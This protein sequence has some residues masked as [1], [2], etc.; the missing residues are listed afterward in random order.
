M[1]KSKKRPIIQS[2]SED[3]DAGSEN[4]LDQVELVNLLVITLLNSHPP[5]LTET[6]KSTNLSK[7]TL[8]PITNHFKAFTN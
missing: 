6:Y 1:S 5:F 7:N 8:G 3:S 2:D 4:V